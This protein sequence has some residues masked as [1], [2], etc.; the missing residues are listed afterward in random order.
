MVPE[1]LL[2]GTRR[3]NEKFDLLYSFIDYIEDKNE[4]LKKLDVFYD[5]I[6]AEEKK[7]WKRLG[8]Y[9]YQD[10]I[11]NSYHE[12]VSY[13]HDALVVFIV[14]EN[15]IEKL[16]DD[17]FNDLMK[18]FANKCEF[19]LLRNI[20][21]GIKT[22]YKVYDM[23][24][25]IKPIK[26]RIVTHKSLGYGKF[27]IEY[28]LKKAKNE[29]DLAYNTET[30]NTYTSNSFRSFY[31]QK[32]SNQKFNFGNPISLYINLVKDLG[33]DP[34][35]VSYDE[36]REVERYDNAAT[37]FLSEEGLHDMLAEYY[38][39]QAITML[40]PTIFY[41]YKEAEESYSYD[42]YRADVGWT[43]DEDD[44]PEDW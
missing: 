17:M 9:P 35:K 8:H 11:Y 23:W 43:G 44:C 3:I 16:F 36:W 12:K 21:D 39:G 25:D 1:S 26:N 2:N 28:C 31:N 27:E 32:L 18:D 30:G 37:R 20:W 41:A 14:L 6:S 38:L 5:F 4:C 42:D 10:T 33:I 22:I 29:F 40:F 19:S 24:N 15:N 13:H 7:A 34:L